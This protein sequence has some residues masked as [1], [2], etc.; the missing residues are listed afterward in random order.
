T[1]ILQGDQMNMSYAIIVHGGAWDIPLDEQEGH[2]VG[3][4]KAARLGYHFMDEGGSAL[5]AVEVAVRSMEEDPVFDAGRGSFL[6]SEADVEMDAM[7]ME[8]KNLDF[9]SVAA[10]QSISHPVTLARR[11]METSPHCMLVGE[12]ALKFAR[13][14][15]M[16][17]VTTAELLTN[18]EFE[19]WKR[20]KADRDYQVRRIFEGD[21]GK[22]E[23]RGTVGA[24]ALDRYG[25]I[26]AATSTGGT[27]NKLPGRVG[28]SPI[29]GCGAYADNDSAGVSTT[30]LGESLM[31]V[32]P[33][34][35]VCDSV[36]NGMTPLDASIETIQYLKRRVNGLGG[37]IALDHKGHMGYAFNTPH[38][39]CASVDVN[40]KATVFI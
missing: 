20:I 9:G 3:C 6:N 17:T 15:C 22:L 21:P 32:I 33:A 26:A 25:L 37:V 34:R 8:G 4:L 28:D 16:E 13:S 1:R 36:K 11:I 19:R 27:P 40:G 10:V 31:K 38:M 2:K 14:I 24:V 12:G 7:I 29:V 30:G 18:K 5:N 35:R 23:K 39:A